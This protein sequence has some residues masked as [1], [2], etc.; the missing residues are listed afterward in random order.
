MID[1][2]DMPSVALE[3][4]NIVHLEEVEMIAALLHQLDENTGFDALSDSYEE[5][6]A[7]MQ[8]HF[9]S[10]EK[11]MKEARFSSYR[12]HKG[13]H[14]KILNEARNVYMDWRNRKEDDRL[15]EF[16]EEDISRWLVQHIKAMD[17]PMAQFLVD[18]IVHCSIR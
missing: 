5:I 6:L 12:L 17:T 4:M 13:E 11:L 15:R 1:E 16:F 10:E 3:S 8:E 7:H 9:S 2:H 18:G 14:D